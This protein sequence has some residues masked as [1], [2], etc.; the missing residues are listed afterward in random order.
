MYGVPYLMYTCIYYEMVGQSEEGNFSTASFADHS[1][2]GGWE[3][4]VTQ[5]AMTWDERSPLLTPG[6]G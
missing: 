6:T 2:R 3:E 5:T 4:T 1:V